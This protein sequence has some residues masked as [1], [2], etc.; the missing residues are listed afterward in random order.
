MPCWQLAGTARNAP[1]QPYT[2]AVTIMSSYSDTASG[3]EA[4]SPALEIMFCFVFLAPE[5]TSFVSLTC[6]KPFFDSYFIFKFSW[7]QMRGGT[8]ELMCFSQMFEEF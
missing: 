5:Q 6:I 7:L 1:G 3:V 8:T 4:S 2:V